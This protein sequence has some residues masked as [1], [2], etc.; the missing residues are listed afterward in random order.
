MDEPTLAVDLDVGGNKAYNVPVEYRAWFVT[1]MRKAKLP[2]IHFEKLRSDYEDQGNRLVIDPK[3][4]VDED[5][6]DIVWNMMAEREW[7]RSQKGFEEDYMKYINM[8]LV[9]PDKSYSN[10]KELF[11]NQY[12][13]WRTNQLDDALS[14]LWFSE[15]VR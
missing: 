15:N 4:V 7:K 10:N 6:R 2:P 1:M 3:T 8:G 11:K 13:A 14:N 9:K 5:P 12:I